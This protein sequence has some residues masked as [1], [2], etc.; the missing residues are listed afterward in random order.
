MSIANLGVIK[1]SRSYLIERKSRVIFINS[2]TSKLEPFLNDFVQNNVYS[3]AEEIDEQ[4][5]N[6][7]EEQITILNDLFPGILKMCIDEWKGD[8]IPV[9][10]ILDEEERINCSLCNA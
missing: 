3:S 5:E 1:L 8:E 10:V 9:K 2:E 7:S 6:F 4:I